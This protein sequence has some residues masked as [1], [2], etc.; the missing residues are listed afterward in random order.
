MSAD[1][2]LASARADRDALADRTD[3]L[4][5]VGVLRMLPDDAHVT[6]DAVASF[7]EVA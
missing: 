5:K 4:D 1:L 2:T 3:V 6:T 7:Y